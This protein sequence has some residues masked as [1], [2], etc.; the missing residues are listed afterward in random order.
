MKKKLSY[1][2]SFLSFKSYSFIEIGKLK[3]ASLKEEIKLLCC[4]GYEK[5]LKYFMNSFKY[6]AID[7]FSMIL[8][9][10]IGEM[11]ER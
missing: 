1:S 9:F 11:N 8:K 7:D 5:R 2:L 6:L 3:A 4:K 10:V